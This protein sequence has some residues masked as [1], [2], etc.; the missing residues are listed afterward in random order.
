MYDGG[1]FFIKSEYLFISKI[2]ILYH[3]MVKVVIFGE[4]YGKT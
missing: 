2:K 1:G 4:I 3:S